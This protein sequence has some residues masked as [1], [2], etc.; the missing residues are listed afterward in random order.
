MVTGSAGFIGYHLSKL[1]LDQG[2]R[3]IGLD[4]L[5]DYYD[6]RLKQRRHAMLAENGNFTP[7]RIGSKTKAC[8]CACSRHTA[9]MP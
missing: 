4:A 9:P 3:V 8:F 1:L 2:W 6:V 5:T 7:S